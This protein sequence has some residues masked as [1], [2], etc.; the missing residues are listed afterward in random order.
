MVALD[1][2]SGLDCDTGEAVGIAVRAEHTVTFAAMKKGF[3]LPGAAAYTGQ[4]S[5]ASIGIDANLLR[6]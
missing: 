2:P 3:Q 4:V 1:I 6:E 5:V